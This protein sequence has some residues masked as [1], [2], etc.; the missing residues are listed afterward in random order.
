MARQ[1]SCLLGAISDCTFYFIQ[2]SLQCS[3]IHDF[4]T[5]LKS[6]RRLLPW[7]FSR[8]KVFGI[9]LNHYF[10]ISDICLGAGIE[11]GFSL[12]VTSRMSRIRKTEKSFILMNHVKL[13]YVQFLHLSFSSIPSS[14][15]RRWRTE[16]SRE[17][18][19]IIKYSFISVRTLRASSRHHFHSSWFIFLLELV[20]SPN[21]KI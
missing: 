12:L 9:E 6:K 4:E 5:N 16:H 8:Y 11:W 1:Y 15:S 13:N 2:V 20:M 7:F 17:E 14:S 10:D 21:L 18:W 3:D 19:D